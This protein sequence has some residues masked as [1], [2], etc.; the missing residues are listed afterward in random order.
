MTDPFLIGIPAAEMVVSE[1][2]AP[3]ERVTLI[4]IA[5][6]LDVTE[7]TV[8]ARAKR[9]RWIHITLPGIGLGQRSRRVYR[10][11][12]LPADVREALGGAR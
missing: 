10:V 4:D 6:A 5:V 11:A 8:R 2:P 1:R 12:G 3:P 7:A 9:G